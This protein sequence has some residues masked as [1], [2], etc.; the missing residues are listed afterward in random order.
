MENGNKILKNLRAVVIEE[1]LSDKQ[2]LDNYKILRTKKDGSWHLH[3]LEIPDSKKAIQEIQS[4]MLS[5]RPYYFHIY[6]NGENLIIVFKEKHFFINPIDKSTWA[7][8]IKYGLSL[9]IPSEQLDFY[10]QKIS[11]ED[12]WL[13][14]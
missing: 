10:P 4:A 3:I 7:D 9:N 8:V 6:D 14:N 13:N 5:D 12:T 2:V 11:D 1:S